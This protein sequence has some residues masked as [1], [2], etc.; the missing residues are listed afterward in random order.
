MPDHLPAPVAPVPA[1]AFI[2]REREV[3]LI[4]GHLT[5]RQRG[6]VA[7]SGPLG[8][9]KTRLL[10]HIAD[11]AVAAAHGAASP[12]HILMH[13]DVQAVAPFSAD[14]FW[15]RIAHLTL[16]AGG[17]AAEDAARELLAR[18]AVDI[19]D[20]EIFLDRLAAAGI[21]LTLLLDEFE[22]AM[23]AGSD[24]EEAASRNFL[25]QL[26]SLARRTPRTL[27]LI[28]ATERPLAEAIAVVPGWRGSPFPTL[29]TAVQ[30]KPLAR[31]AA[32]RLIDVFVAEGSPSWTLSEVDR[33]G[34]YAASGGR[35]AALEAA[36]RSLDLS[37]AQGLERHAARGMAEA[38]AA[39]RLLDLRPVAAHAPSATVTLLP[40][41]GER[42]I[43]VPAAR[44]GLW[45]DEQASEVYVHGHRVGGLTALEYNLLALF[46]RRPGQVC[47]KRDIL[48]Q[49][50]GE[51][52]A[53]G[54]DVT[55]VEKLISRLRAKIE[56]RP[57]RPQLI[58]TVRGRGYRYVPEVEDAVEMAV[59]A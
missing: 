2:N 51:E 37:R 40:S 33:H 7:I 10:H 28:I 17:P 47:G 58:R 4:F 15:Q 34:I 52:T 53:G 56:S 39:E 6:N 35:P 24:A 29:F 20:V 54:I 22:W 31:E 49:L 32:D 46:Y 41:T 38:A 57:G 19:V 55:R 25:A 12:A 59:S 30:L 21:I 16:R 8:M 23:Q 27:A 42:L 36:V 1:Q 5:A 48:R 50:W 26:A 13:V 3:D 9:G 11:P 45:L 14:R 18:D 43:Y 44:A